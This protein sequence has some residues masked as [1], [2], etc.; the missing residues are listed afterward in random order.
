MNIFHKLSELASGSRTYQDIA[1][2][3]E[4]LRKSGK[5]VTV[6]FEGEFQAY[7]SRIT[8]FNKEHKVF[9]LSNLFP[10]AQHDT[11]QNGRT[12]TISSTD[13]GK[14]ISIDGVCLEPLVN[15]ADMGYELKISGSISVSDV[16]KSPELE[17][18]HSINNSEEAAQE[19]KVVGL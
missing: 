9:V 17:A 1:A 8:A 15:G 7:S 14:T 4:R 18:R 3:L 10:P 6:K 12:A 16:E 2:E 5:P 11:F 19:R 13:D